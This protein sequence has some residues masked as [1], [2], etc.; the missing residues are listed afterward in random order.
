MAAGLD[1]LPHLVHG[2]FLN[3]RVS[4]AAGGSAWYQPEA[5][6]RKVY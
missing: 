6:A 3:L 5:D 1:T 2:F 4:S